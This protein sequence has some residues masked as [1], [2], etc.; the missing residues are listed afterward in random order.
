[1]LDKL[2]SHNR[3][4]LQSLIASELENLPRSS[5]GGTNR[6]SARSCKEVFQASDEG[7][8]AFKDEYVSTEHC[9]SGWP[10]LKNKARN[11]LLLSGVTSRRFAEAASQ[12]SEARRGLTIPMPSRTYQALEK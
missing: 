2:K 8:V 5:G 3:W 1:M 11:L 12:K 10:G 9:A 7:Q 6:A 4:R